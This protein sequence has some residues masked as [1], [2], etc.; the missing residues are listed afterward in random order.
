MAQAAGGAPRFFA[1]GQV[2]QGADLPTLAA[3]SLDLARVARHDEHPWNAPL[4]VE[5]LVAQGQRA[6]EAA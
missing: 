5:A 3:W 6:W 1:P 4:R 2:P